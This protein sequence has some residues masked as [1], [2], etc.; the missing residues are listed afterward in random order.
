MLKGST[1]SLT[2]R[3][4]YRLFEFL[5]LAW[6][7]GFL[8]FGS[9]VI[10]TTSCDSE[11]C[12]RL[13]FSEGQFF[14]YLSSLIIVFGV[15]NGL[16]IATMYYVTDPDRKP[17]YFFYTSLICLSL[18]FIIFGFDPSGF[19]AVI[20]RRSA[21][22]PN[23]LF[24]MLSLGVATF[25]FFSEPNIWTKLVPYLRLRV[26]FSFFLAIICLINPTFGL[27]AA[28]LLVPVMVLSLFFMRE[29]E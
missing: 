29:V 2:T 19:E 11:L 24:Y 1:P 6:F 21:N 14:R 5:D 3:V 26:G 18:A 10:Y 4:S 12:Q 22:T 15:V 17:E 8:I 20:G 13:V 25:S 23:F 9:F 16:R 27:V 7:G 28:I